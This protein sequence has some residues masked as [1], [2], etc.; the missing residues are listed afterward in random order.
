MEK[1]LFEKPV[2]NDTRA[3]NNTQ[4]IATGRGDDYTTGYLLDYV[5]FKNYF[6]MI[7]IDLSKQKPLDD[8][9]KSIQ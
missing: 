2:E 3:N 5:N 6:E 7:A 8:D 1:N 9:P 4:K